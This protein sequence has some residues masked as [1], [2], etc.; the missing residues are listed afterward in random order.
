M[1]ANIQGFFIRL[2]EETINENCCCR[3]SNRVLGASSES[4]CSKVPE[5]KETI[6]N[7]STGISFGSGN[8]DT[9]DSVEEGTC[10]FGIRGE[11]LETQRNKCYAGSKNKIM[12]VEKG[13]IVSQGYGD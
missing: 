4:G 9:F 5:R 10:I 2:F 13:V 7:R 8:N 1:G 11:I 12:A 6:E 3:K